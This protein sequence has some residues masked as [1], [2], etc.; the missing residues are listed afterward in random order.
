M[1]EFEFCVVQ[2]PN[3]T[4]KLY[5]V[6]L[7]IDKKKEKDTLISTSESYPLVLSLANNSTGQ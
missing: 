1:I 5:F 7:W 4:T 3:R 6:N 2:A